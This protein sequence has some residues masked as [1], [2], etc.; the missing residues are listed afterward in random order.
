MPFICLLIALLFVAIP[1]TARDSTIIKVHFLY[2]SKPKNQYKNTE[3]KWFGGT[4]GGHVGIEITHNRIVS[5]NPA[6]KFHW[7]AHKQNKHGA[8]LIHD[9]IQFYSLF[10]GKPDRVKKMVIH[11]P[12]SFAQALLLD[13]L[14]KEYLLNTPYGYAFLGM[15]CGAAAYHLLSHIDIIPSKQPSIIQWKIFYPRK[16]RKRLLKLSEKHHWPVERQ[17]GSNTRKWEQ[18]KPKLADM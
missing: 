7:V 18:D 11:I 13:S 6:G 8:F 10:G 9:S 5:F 3:Q 2:G 15:R 12:V 14:T 17:Q 4:L 16:L 1:S